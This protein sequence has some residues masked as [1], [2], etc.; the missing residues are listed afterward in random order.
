MPKTYQLEDLDPERPDLEFKGIKYLA[1][2]PDDFGLDTEARLLNLKTRLEKVEGSKKL[3][4]KVADELEE[5][6]GEIIKI[7]FPD[8]PMDIIKKIPTTK[9]I[10]IMKWWGEECFPQAMSRL[11]NRNSQAA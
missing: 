9:K 3:S 1:A 11:T 6:M 10:E 8:L 2:L 4:V 5:I 7:Y